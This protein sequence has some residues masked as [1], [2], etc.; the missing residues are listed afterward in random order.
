MNTLVPIEDV[1]RH[2]SVS[3]STVRKWIRDGVIPDNMYVK[4][5]HTQRFALERVADA[6]MRYDEKKKPES[7]DLDDD[8]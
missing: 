3:L 1:A 4:V 2:F 8:V 6:L 5:G 7:L